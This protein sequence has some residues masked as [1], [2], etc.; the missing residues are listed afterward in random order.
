M[1][2]PSYSIVFNS[3]KVNFRVKFT[4]F[5]EEMKLLFKRKPNQLFAAFLSAFFSG[6]RSVDEPRHE[7]CKY[8][9]YHNLI[10]AQRRRNG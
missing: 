3:I 4:L 10:I 6:D 7:E 8:R 5:L 9:F 1:L 2:L